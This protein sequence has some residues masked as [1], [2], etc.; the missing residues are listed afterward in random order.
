VHPRQEDG[1]RGAF[2]KLSRYCRENDAQ[3]VIYDVFGECSL[4]ERGMNEMGAAHSGVD[5]P[6]TW[7]EGNGRG[8]EGL[9]G[10]QAYG[11]SGTSVQPVR[12]GGQLV[13]GVFEDDYATYCLLGGLGPRDAGDTNEQQAYT[14][15]LRMEAAL[16]T[17]GMDFSHVVRT[18]LYIDGILDWYGAFNAARTRFFNERGI[19]E[20]TV[21]AS[22]GIGVRNPAG[23]AIVSDLVAVRPRD[24]SVTINA[25]PSP[26]QCPATDYKSSFSRALEVDFPDH[27]RLYISGTASI[28]EHG[29]TDHV[30][31]VEGQ[32]DLSMRVV[33]AILESTGMQWSDLSRA[34]AYFR[35]SADVPLFGDYCSKNGLPPMPIAIAHADIC[36]DDLLFE[37]EVDAVT[38]A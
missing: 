27:R 2:E 12:I 16:E 23:T 19:F 36:R 26:M 14:T 15:F 20:L 29:E 6:V 11:V 17:A 13:G 32:I 30:G 1:V 25:L 28:D 3:L 18:W 9:T 21:P 7:I 31:D 35:N 8:S 24:G 33:E 4:Y 22:T 34:V 37:I 38:G 5:W 10:I